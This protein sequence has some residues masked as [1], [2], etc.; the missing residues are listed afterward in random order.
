[1]ENSAKNYAHNWWECV[2]D[3]VMIMVATSAF[4]T[5]IDSPN[6]RAVLMLGHAAASLLD[7]AQMAGRAGRDGLAAICASLWLEAEVRP[8]KDGRRVWIQSNIE[9]CGDARAWARDTKNCRTQ[10]L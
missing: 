7:Y 5:G 9:G 10:G 3:A 1:M 2:N 4:G 8:D 6:V